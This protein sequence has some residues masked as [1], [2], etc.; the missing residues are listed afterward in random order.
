MLSFGLSL[1]NFQKNPNL[2]IKYT[3]SKILTDSNGVRYLKNNADT[4]ARGFYKSGRTVELSGDGRVEVPINSA[5]GADSSNSFTAITSGSVVSTATGSSCDGA[6][7]TTGLIRPSVNTGYPDGEMSLVEFDVSNLVGTTKLNSYY[8]GANYIPIDVPIKS[9]SRIS[10]KAMVRPGTNYV[11]LRV[12][13]NTVW[14]FDYSN[15]SIKEVQS[16]QGQITYYDALQKKHIGIGENG[17]EALPLSTTYQLKDTTF[18]NLVVLWDRSFTQADRDL[19]D[20]EPELVVRW[21]LGEDV[22]SIGA[23]GVNDKVYIGS[24]TDAILRSMEDTQLGIQGTYSRQ[25][26]LNYGLQTLALKLN[27]A[28]VPTALADPNT[29]SFVNNTSGLVDT[30]FLPNLDTYSIEW[31]GVIGGV[32]TKRLITHDIINGDNYYVDGVLT[33][34]TPALPDPNTR[35]VLNN[36][37]PIGYPD[38]VD[39][40]LDPFIVSS[41]VATP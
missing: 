30:Q 22:F 40:V 10:F 7:T 26:Q 24:D 32:A 6:G 36:T 39:T 33:T 3:F 35:I 25:T 16:T 4:T 37:A 27:S 15:L 20:L 28:G 13:A 19:M 12:D 17:T 14:S 38:T 8:D 2:K 29:L 41:T 34:P 5:L 9:N 1:G 11:Q 31:N 18:N 21:A 23:I